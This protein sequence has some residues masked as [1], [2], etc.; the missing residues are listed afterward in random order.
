MKK[1][2]CF[3][4][5]SPLT[6]E[7][8]LSKH[9]E[10]LSPLFDIYLVA[11]FGGH[12]YQNP[13]V[14]GIKS[15]PIKRNI[16]ISSDLRALSTL[17]KYLKEMRFDAVHT[18]TPKAGLLG[19]LAGKWAGVKVRTHIFTGQVWHTKT[20]IFKQVLKTLDKI[21][22][23]AATHILVDGQSQRQFLIKN[24]IVTEKNSAVLGKG[25]ISGVDVTRFVPDAATRQQA[26]AGL[27]MSDQ[28]IF[29]FLG[30]M[31]R[32]KGLLDL[33]RAFAIHHRQFPDSRLVLVGPD[34][35][36]ITPAIREICSSCADAVVFY[37]ST[38]K[39]FEILQAADVFCLPSYR[40]GF[41]TSVIEASLLELPVISSDTYGLMETIVEGST[42][43]RHRVGDAAGIAHRMSELMDPAL[44]QTMGKNGR[45]YVL[46]HF[47]AEMI[48]SQWVNF[49]KRILG[50]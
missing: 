48:S 41:G 5:A 50:A 27:K 17:R 47:S 44:R 30:R 4:V 43:L 2:I 46:D 20:G 38:N 14:K 3:I 6:A 28:V 22:V 34:E 13:F 29:M 25:S 40:E 8:F 49:Y 12:P 9:F 32:D 23:G 26:R 24:N 35:E 7:A 15:I 21:I 19:T 1:K 39:P 16:S 42:G 18:V 11:D 45:Q 10:Y 37:G 33:A 36:G 31:N